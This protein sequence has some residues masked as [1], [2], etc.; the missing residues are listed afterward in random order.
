MLG[1]VDDG[2]SKGSVFRVQMAA[3][4]IGHDRGLWMGQDK[5]EVGSREVREH[6]GNLP[7]KGHPGNSGPRDGLKGLSSHP[8]FVNM[9]ESPR[10]STF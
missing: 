5:V 9:T 1:T 6:R 2:P 10:I 8:N 3:G 7:G 4:G